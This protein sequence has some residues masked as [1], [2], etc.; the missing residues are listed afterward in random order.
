MLDSSISSISVRAA[1]TS[2]IRFMVLLRGV[3]VIAV[4]PVS[5]ASGKSDV[6]MI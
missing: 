2:L 4:F 1:L 3:D 5:L 6:T